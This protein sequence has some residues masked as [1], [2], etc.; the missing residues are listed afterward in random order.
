VDGHVLTAI[1][2][3]S[4][5][6]LDLAA[7]AIDGGTLQQ[8]QA[9]FDFV[10]ACLPEADWKYLHDRLHDPEDGFE[11]NDLVPIMVWLVEEF[12][13]RPTVPPSEPSVRPLSTSKRS[14]GTS[15]RKGSTRSA[16]A[17]KGSSTRS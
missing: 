13:E 2:P 16:S 6:L 15:S 1:E 11:L 8:V 4:A 10:Q 14:T 5:A 3:K 7:T 17:R 9:A 12:L